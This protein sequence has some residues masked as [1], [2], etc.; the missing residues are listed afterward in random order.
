MFNLQGS[1]LVIILLLALVVL[2]PEKLP[3]AMR[4]AGQFFAELKKMSAGFQS[5]F[6]AAVDE[7]MREI[8]DTAN[9]LRDS[10]DFTK[11]QEGGREEKP[12]S[13]EMAPADPDTTPGDEIPTFEPAVDDGAGGPSPT[14]D[15]KPAP[16]SGQSSAAPRPRRGTSDS[17]SAPEPATPVESAP[18]SADENGTVDGTDDASPGPPERA[19]EPVAERDEQPPA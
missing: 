15:S 3:D 12:K 19:A 5:E 2:G 1:E 9:V 13:A 14:G 11:L 8:R 10:A 4:R 18:E 6:R 7:P 16:F 17:V